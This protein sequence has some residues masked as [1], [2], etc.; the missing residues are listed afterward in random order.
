M[1]AAAP[2]GSPSPSP[3]STASATATLDKAV[4]KDLAYMC[5]EERFARD[6]YTAIAKL[7]PDATAFTNIAKAEQRHMDAVGSLLEL[8]LNSDD[9]TDG[10]KAELL[11][12]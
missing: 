1:A 2:P 5:E 11:G 10:A 6:V 3:T 7:Y 12:R 4:A 9:P 8:P